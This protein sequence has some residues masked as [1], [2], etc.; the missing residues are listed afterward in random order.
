[1]P[2]HELVF[3][4]ARSLPHTGMVLVR[5]GL[6]MK[7]LL[8]CMFMCCGGLSGQNS[9]I[10]T[11][12]SYTLPSPIYAAPGQLVTVIVAGVGYTFL[13]TTR[14]AP[15]VDLPPSLAGVSLGFWQNISV[16][17]IPILEVHPFWTCGGQEPYLCGPLLAVTVQIPFEAQCVPCSLPNGGVAEGQLSVQLNG[18]PVTISLYATIEGDQVHVLTNCDTFMSGINYAPPTAGLPCPSIVTHADGSMVSAASPA[19]AG[20]ELVAYAV[21]LGQTNPA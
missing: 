7:S 18:S 9:P 1:V 12:S 10:L 2:D 8:V 15:G 6:N 5:H 19:K 11:G 13:N 4:G 16:P 3:A 21:G 20:E 17:G 14:A